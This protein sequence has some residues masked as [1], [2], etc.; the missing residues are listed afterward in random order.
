MRIRRLSLSLLV[1]VLLL[2]CP[3]S[4]RID[5][6]IQMRLGNP[7]KASAQP[8]S[9]G[10]FLIRRPQYALAYNADIGIP[11]WVA[12]HV[13]KEDLGE[14]ARGVFAPDTSLPPGFDPVL[15]TDYKRSGYDRGHGCPS[16]DRTATRRDNDATFLM[17]NMIPQAAGL[18]RGPWEKLE[19]YTRTLVRQGMECYVICGVGPV[20]KKIGQGKVGVPSF[21]W[22]V[23]VV[24]PDQ[25]GNDLKRITAQTRVIAVRM[26][27]ITTISRKGWRAFRVKA[28]DIEQA[29]GARLLTNV[30]AKV[31]KCL[32]G[33]LDKG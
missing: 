2:A 15:P 7:S 9:R 28:S 14:E 23:I 4:A 8:A 29:T 33:K 31:R 25:A 20:T 18:N 21:M 19:S 3:L 17:T 24:L 6:R 26:P 11:K 27:N 13:S 12:W 5:T 22:K 10:N 16:G 30:P 32:K 1:L